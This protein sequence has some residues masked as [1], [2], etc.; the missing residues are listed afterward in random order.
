RARHAANLMARTVR[1]E[2][3]PTMAFRTLPLLWS[4]AKMIDAEPPMSLVVEKLREINARAGV[5]S[6]SLG[7]GYQWIDNPTVGASAIVVTDGN[8][9]LAQACVEELGRWV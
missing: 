9:A 6:A 8:E 7:V 2:I 3:R 4:A 1:G 5:L